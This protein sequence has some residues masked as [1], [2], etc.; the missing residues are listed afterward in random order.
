MKKN[1]VIIGTGY[2][3]TVVGACFA[4][5]GHQV[6]CVDIDKEKIKKL[7]K[8]FSPIYEPG[9]Q[10]IIRANL[11]QGRLHFTTSLPEALKDA[12]AVFI[13]VGTPSKADGSCEMKYVWQ[14]ARNIGQNLDHY[15][16]VANKSTVPVGTASKVKEII[17]KYYDNDFDVVSNPEFQR[18]GSSVKD[19][20]MPDRIVIGSESN[21]AKK[22]MLQIYEKIKAPKLIMDPE[23]AEMVK[24]AANAFLA[25]KISYINEIANICERVGA[26]VGTVAEGVGMDKR[27][28]YSFLKAGLGYGGS[29]FPKDVKALHNIAFQDGYDFKLLRGVIKV[30]QQ[31][32]D[33]VVNKIK[34]LL[35]Q[36]L[37]DK[38]VAV[39]GLAFKNNTDDIRESASI[40]IINALQKSKIKIYAYDPMAVDNARKVLNHKV[41]YF[42]NPYKAVENVDLAVIATE[43]PEFVE[44]NWRRIK[45]LMKTPK[46][47]DGRNL[48]E[49]AEMEGLGFKYDAVG[50]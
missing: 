45:K 14:V 25:T 46:V 1:I 41:R 18:E 4:K 33:L 43:W 40:D 22:I 13:A 3:G 48:L 2:V 16:V 8:G 11:Y 37:K 19:F 30:N 49:R 34:R 24:Y 50:R 27:I 42:K 17:K 9:L 12:E 10:K 31:Q 38:K 39:L 23:S 29:C 35:G 20:L 44:L 5:F 47:V 26:D 32:R 7:K 36:K 28:G 6:T 15:V 21:R